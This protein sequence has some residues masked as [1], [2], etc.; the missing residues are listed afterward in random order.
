MAAHDIALKLLNGP[1]R[2][3]LTPAGVEFT[4]HLEVV[5]AFHRMAMALA[6]L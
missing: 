4:F 6:Y 5:N 1:L 2:H 3:Q